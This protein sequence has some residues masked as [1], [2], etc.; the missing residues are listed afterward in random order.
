MSDTYTSP[1]VSPFNWKYHGNWQTIESQISGLG[2]WYLEETKRWEFV[3]PDP[4]TSEKKRTT[5][6]WVWN[7]RSDDRSAATFSPVESDVIVEV[8]TGRNEYM[9]VSHN[10]D[11]S[12]DMA[13]SVPR[14]NANNS[15]SDSIPSSED[16][17]ESSP[18]Q[19]F[20]W[21]QIYP[22]ARNDG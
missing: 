5:T 20:Q 6:M 9:Q 21:N 19:N 8:E 14:R 17:E 18:G 4:P 15:C 16:F 1:E 12:E 7:W 22:N 2:E 3:T 11:E 13:N 10:Q